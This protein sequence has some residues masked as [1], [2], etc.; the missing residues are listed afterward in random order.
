[1]RRNA[2]QQARDRAEQGCLVRSL[3][4][5]PKELQLTGRSASQSPPT[6]IALI[7]AI[8]SVERANAI[9]RQPTPRQYGLCARV[10]TDESQRKRISAQ[11]AIEAIFRLHGSLA[12]G[13]IVYIIGN[14]YYHVVAATGRLSRRSVRLSQAISET[15]ISSGV[16]PASSFFDDEPA[17]GCLLLDRAYAGAPMS[18]SLKVAVHCAILR[19]LIPMTRLLLKVGIGAGEFQRLVQRAYV[20]AARDM[21]SDAGAFDRPNITPNAV[22]TGLSRIEVAR[23][24]ESEGEAQ[25]ESDRGRQRAERVL[26]GWWANPDF[27]DAQGSPA[28]LP[29][30]GPRVSFE[31]LVNRYSGEPRTAA[32][33]K[34]LLRVR[35]VRR[36]PDGRVQ[37]LS[38]TVASA[39]FDADGIAIIAEQLAEHLETLLYNAEHPSRPRFAKRVV[40]A[41]LAE[42]HVARLVR[43]IEQ[44]L[45][46]VGDAIDD[47]INDPQVTVKPKEDPA[48]VRALAI[49]F[50]ISEQELAVEPASPPKRQSRAR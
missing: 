31:A 36:L 37:A 32:I 27:H 1:M 2:I 46:T 23:I 9:P 10:V 34:E 42:R 25:P 7:R 22:Q 24:L 5:S 11:L 16:L 15:F 43:D 38:R 18:E 44:Q 45:D 4:G 49:T 33:L 50:Y 17:H 28:P 21:A 30:H 12:H 48:R 6:R 35:A 20:R 8:R 39:R 47:E 40:N 14:F 19:I 26:S 3:C 29:L 13:V 41:R